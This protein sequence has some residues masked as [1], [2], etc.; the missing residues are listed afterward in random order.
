MAGQRGDETTGR[1][2]SV[3]SERQHGGARIRH[4]FQRRFC[5]SGSAVRVFARRIRDERRIQ[6]SQRGLAAKIQSWRERAR[7]DARPS[8]ERRRRG[9]RSR[10]LRRRDA[11]VQNVARHAFSDVG[12]GTVGG[13]K[14]PRR[15]EDVRARDI[16]AHA[17]AAESGDGNRKRETR[18]EDRTERRTRG[19]ENR[20]EFT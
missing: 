1:F 4:V 8:R 7:V 6:F 3:P 16:S 9:N 18:E 15:L 13:E 12:T 2:Q 14:R 11:D 10:V 5:E 19:D 17:R 20:P